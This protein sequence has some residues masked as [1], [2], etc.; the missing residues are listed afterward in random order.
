MRRGRRL[1]ARA[2]R[3]NRRV[4]SGAENR[5]VRTARFEDRAGTIIPA[6]HRP[7]VYTGLSARAQRQTARSGI[8]DI[9]P[10]ERAITGGLIAATP[11]ASAIIDPSPTNLALGA[12]G[13]V[14]AGRVLEELGL[15]V[16][17]V[18]AAVAGREARDF[19][20]FWI[21]R[22]R[23]NL[24][25]AASTGWAKPESLT[26]RG[27]RLGE[28]IRG[29]SNKVTAKGFRADQL[30]EN[31]PTHRYRRRKP[32]DEIRRMLGLPTR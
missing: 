19:A 26:T 15:P 12:V 7:S 1:A 24:T 32:S 14:P 31:D 10:L 16:S 28:A 30:L 27:G 23:Y 2:G 3:Q 18:R 29:T 6:L 8:Q 20:R 17:A 13:L 4:S 25:N 22:A 11:G 21:D 5:A 9:S